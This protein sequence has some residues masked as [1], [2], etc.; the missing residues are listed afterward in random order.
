MKKKECYN[1]EMAGETFRQVLQI[2]K[3]KAPGRKKDEGQASLC[4][5]GLCVFF[6]MFS[7]WAEDPAGPSLRSVLVANG[8]Q[9]LMLKVKKEM[10]AAPQVI[11][12]F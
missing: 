10:E 2:C 6:A 5:T 3:G 1:P 11:H 12:I 7:G 9:I 8:G 4:L